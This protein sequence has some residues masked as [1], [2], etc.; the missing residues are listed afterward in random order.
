MAKYNQQDNNDYLLENNLL[1]I[2]S[3]EELKKAESF[4]FTLRATA[5]ERGGFTFKSYTKKEFKL[6]HYYLFQDMYPFAVKFRYVQLTKGNT[7]FCQVQFLNNYAIELFEQMKNEP[8]WQSLDEAAERLAYFKSEL[9][10]LHPFREG[11]GRTIRIFLYEYAKS[12]S[13]E[14]SY[15]VMDKDRYI[16][17]MIEAILNIKSLKELFSETISWVQ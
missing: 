15:E 8:L 3:F 1:G 13:V 9:N 14:W 4:A 2:T 12:K 5:L 6:L 16:Q 10:M 11:N 17:A 7:R